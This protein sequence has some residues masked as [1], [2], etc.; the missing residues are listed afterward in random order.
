M[1][2]E[3]LLRGRDFNKITLTGR[4]YRTDYGN[5]A[6]SQ[7]SPVLVIPS[8]YNL[9]SL[10]AYRTIPTLAP[11]P[12]PPPP[13][14]SPPPLPSPPQGTREPRANPYPDPLVQIFAVST[15]AKLSLAI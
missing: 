3:F 1:P 11:S 10:S 14:P 15:P 7:T 12:P 8:P 6:G 13:P 5:S 2:T 4:Y 9:H